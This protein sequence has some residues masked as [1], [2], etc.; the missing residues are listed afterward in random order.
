MFHEV[1]RSTW[2]SPHHTPTE[3][4]SSAGYQEQQLHQRWYGSSNSDPN[5][6]PH[7]PMMDPHSSYYVHPGSREMW[8]QETG[9]LYEEPSRMQRS[10]HHP[11]MTM[12][13]ITQ[14]SDN[15]MQ[16]GHDTCCVWTDE[17]MMYPAEQQSQQQ[18]HHSHVIHYHSQPQQ[19]QQVGWKHPYESPD[20]V[21]MQ[22]MTP[23]SSGTTVLITN[24]NMRALDGEEIHSTHEA[25]E[26]LNESRRKPQKQNSVGRW[27]A[28]EHQWFLKGLEMFQGPSWG[29]IAR[30]IG[31]RTST[32][33]RTHA[34]KFFTKMARLNQTFPHFEIQIQKERQ[35]LL[36]QGVIRPNNGGG[37]NGS[38]SS[39]I[40][41][42]S[43]IGAAL[44]NASVTPTSAS[45]ILMMN[46]KLSPSK[47]EATVSLKRPREDSIVHVHDVSYNNNTSMAMTG[48]D[49]A[50][51]KKEFVGEPHE[52]PQPEDVN[53]AR[54]WQ[55]QKGNYGFDT[56]TS[57][58]PMESPST[59]WDQC[60]WN[61]DYPSRNWT[62]NDMNIPPTDETD[63][64][65]LPSMN[66][67]LYRGQ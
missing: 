47:R 65:S 38:S 9:Y 3:R 29:E 21:N 62:S 39:N 60:Q 45:G 37:G 54:T 30:L 23:S 12:F 59:E 41:N 18:P 42:D 16:M 63:P 6:G 64:E 17:K 19:Q 27:T 58:A 1:E 51:I 31:T 44:V 61:G 34:Q 56:T 52:E 5:I 8:G 4:Q 11:N 13:N 53:S 15:V 55:D 25:R 40:M 24:N 28:E 46:N 2:G 43:G 33:V 20:P 14:P 7:D 10:S 26:R 50:T 48:N 36:G 49:A 22:F 35:R 57:A 32:Q 66:Q 67:M